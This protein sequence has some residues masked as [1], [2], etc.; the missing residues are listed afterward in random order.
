MSNSARWLAYM[1]LS[2]FSRLLCGL[3]GNLAHRGVVKP[4]L[5]SMWFASSHCMAWGRVCLG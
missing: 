5:T 3:Y 1:G 2:V 4:C